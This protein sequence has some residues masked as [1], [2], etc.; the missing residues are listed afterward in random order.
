MSGESDRPRRRL[1]KANEAADYLCISVP[2]LNRLAVRGDIPSVT[3]SQRCRRYDPAALDRW[4][5][6]RIEEGAKG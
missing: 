6:A 5:S 3:L 4:I 2:H 1:L